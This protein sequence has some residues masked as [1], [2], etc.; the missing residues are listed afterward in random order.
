MPRCCTPRQTRL[1][2]AAT[3]RAT[4]RAN[5]LAR[6][7]QIA[8]PKSPAPKHIGAKKTADKKKPPCQTCGKAK[9]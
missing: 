8:P 4:A 2:I 5:A 9:P 1:Q 7:A 6:K 3:R